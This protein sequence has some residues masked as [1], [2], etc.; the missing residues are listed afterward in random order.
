MFHGSSLGENADS[1][2]SKWTRR[3]ESLQPSHDIESLEKAPTLSEPQEAK[4][5]PRFHV[6]SVDHD[7]WSHS[8]HGMT[9]LMVA[10]RFGVMRFSCPLLNRDPTLVLASDEYRMHDLRYGGLHATD[11]RISSYYH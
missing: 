8:P 3:F 1:K 10:S 6:Y 2:A 7:Q 4:F 5:R 11:M 9:S